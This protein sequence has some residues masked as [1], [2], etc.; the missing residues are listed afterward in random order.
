MLLKQIYNLNITSADL[1]LIVD[2]RENFRNLTAICHQPKAFEHPIKDIHDTF[3]SCVRMYKWVVEQINLL[4]YFHYFLEQLHGNNFS[5]I[6]EFLAHDFKK[7]GIKEI[8]IQSKTSFV[9]II[10]P[11]MNDIIL[12]PQ[13]KRIC[14][15][16]TYLRTSNIILKI[17]Q[18]ITNDKAKKLPAQFNMN[19]FYQ[20]IW[21]PASDSSVQVLENLST[22]S[23]LIS[24]M[25]KYF[26]S[27]KD[28]VTITQ[29][30]DNLYTGCREYQN[31]HTQQNKYIP[32][33]CA[34]K[35]HLY[36]KLQNCSEAACLITQLKHALNIVSN[37][38]IIEN[39]INIK[40]AYQT[41][42][43]NELNENVSAVA[44]NLGQL[45]LS[46]LEVIR[47]IIDRVEFIIWVRSNLKNLN[48]LKTFIDISLTT[49]GGNPV[50]IDRI[51]CLSSVCINFA[52]LIF[53]ID[54]NTNYEILIARCKQVIESVKRSRELTKL[55]REVGENVK[56]W[57]EMKQSHGSVEESRNISGVEHGIMFHVDIASTVQFGIESILFKLLI[58]GGICK[59]NGEL[60]HCRQRD[61]YVIEITL[62]SVQST[63][64]QF[65]RLFQT[66]NVFNLLMHS[67]HLATLTHRPLI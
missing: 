49:C 47:A 46:N 58:L 55:L 38:D 26:D 16:S 17:F 48:E 27:S 45:S 44:M 6:S 42:Q 62:T 65:S 39:I 1:E 40:Q 14:R 4:T 41:K 30:L 23:I 59:S 60:W 7:K 67:K 54:K 15:I 32:P 33:T 29:D 20:E 9:L 61:Y 53:Q 2:N 28:I 10:S 35:I 19:I 12:F 5:I 18:T 51:T 21:I 11:E 13:F 52:P 36:F 34:K 8:C 63:S 3:E 43:L 31:D 66:Y 50:D 37:F 56:F 57:E 64:S 25:C 24:D 22:E